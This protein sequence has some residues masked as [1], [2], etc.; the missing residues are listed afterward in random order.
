MSGDL[1]GITYVPINSGEGCVPTK[2]LAFTCSMS[3][4]LWHS[5]LSSMTIV[6]IFMQ[7][8][9]VGPLFPRPCRQ[10]KSI[11]AVC[12]VELMKTRL[13][14]ERCVDAFP[15]LMATF[16]ACQRPEK[17]HQGLRHG[18]CD[19]RI[20]PCDSQDLYL[21]YTYLDCCREI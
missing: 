13:L 10:S 19:R 4:D 20:R 7:I 18:S 2:T 16:A 9:V 8:S 5:G 1:I 17:N 11:R 21:R 14:I 12:K 15:W 6:P 3:Y